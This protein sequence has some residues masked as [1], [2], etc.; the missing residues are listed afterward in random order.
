MGWIKD[1]KI[2]ENI[3]LERD[4]FT[5]AQWDIYTKLFCGVSDGDDIDVIVVNLNSVDYFDNNRKVYQMGFDIKVGE[6]VSNNELL[7]LFNQIENVI[8]NFYDSHG[9]RLDIKSIGEFNVE[10]ITEQYKSLSDN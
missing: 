9:K 4:E 2:K 3:T 8:N 1:E 6:N 7:S 5:K 10:N